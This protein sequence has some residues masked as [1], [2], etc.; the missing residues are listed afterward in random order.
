MAA[1]IAPSRFSRRRWLAHALWAAPSLVAGDA[2]WVEPDWIAV[3]TRR[4][5]DAPKT[6][7]VQFTDVH[8]KGNDARLRR[9]VELVNGLG[10]DFACFTGDLIE[11]ARF[12]APA[13][14]ILAGLRCP[15]FGVP[16][17]HD[18]WSRADFG[19]FR[20]TFAAT[21]GAWMMDE[22]RV[23]PGGRVRMMGFDRSMARLRPEPGVFNLVLMHYPAWADD[24]PFRAEL[25]LAGHTH[26][27]QVRVPFYGALATP[28]E[29]GRYEMGAYETPAGPLYVNPGIGTLLMDVRLN[30][31]PEL[32]VFEV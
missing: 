31:R 27:G 26:G 2:G 13:L 25:L 16:G 30:C 5:S 29:S 11:E 17:N 12:A 19:A 6:R 18:H 15:L 8:H 7:F 20:R 22:V 24:L 14:D 3:R 21:G 10:P 23:A 1:T 32:T 9:L 4:M 28:Q